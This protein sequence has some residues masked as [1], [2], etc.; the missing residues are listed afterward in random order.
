MRK[1]LGGVS[2]LTVLVLSSLAAPLYA[3]HSKAFKRTATAQRY[4][5]TKEVTM[6]GT[7]QGI[8]KKPARGSV[9]G[10]H[11]MVST[12]KGT[13]D[14]HIGSFVTRGPHAFSPAA[15]QSVKITGV[16]TTVNHKNLFLTRTIESGNR[17][18]Q[19]RDKHGFLIVPGVKG[20]IATASVKGGAR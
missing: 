14:A 8:V 5:V 18:I 11:L 20:R 1:L 2:L 3:A 16:M 19:V 12:G 9:L 17:T 13:I 4:D 10:E 7:I 15:G 6:E